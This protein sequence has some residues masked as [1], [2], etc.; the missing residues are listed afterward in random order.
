[1]KRLLHIHVLSYLELMPSTHRPQEKPWMEGRGSK[2]PPHPTPSSRASLLCGCFLLS[3]SKM[4]LALK[5]L[6]WGVYGWFYIF[7]F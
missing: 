3:P 4:L 6:S 2:A 5:F 1:M 7:F